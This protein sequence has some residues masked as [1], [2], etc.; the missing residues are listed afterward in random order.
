MKMN[1]SCLL[2]AACVSEDEVQTSSTD[3][4]GTYRTYLHT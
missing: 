3:D 4:D 1:G 2:C